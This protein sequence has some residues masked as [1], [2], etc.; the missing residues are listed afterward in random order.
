MRMIFHLPYKIDKNHQSGSNIRP[1]KMINA[2]KN[3]GY[4]VD[5]VMGYGKERKRQISLIKGKIKNGVQYD[6]LYSE[7]S[8][9][10]T[11]LTEK[12]H[13]PTYPFLDYNF[14][15]YCKKQGIKIGLFYRDIYWNFNDYKN[16]VSLLKRLYSLLFYKYDLFK[17]NKLLDVLYLPSTLM[18]EYIP[19]D[20]GIKIESLP[21]GVN[22]VVVEEGLKAKDNSYLEIFYV[23]GIG[24]LYNL[25]KI[26]QATKK[27]K[28]IKL[29]V[30]T[31]KK[32][33]D[34]EKNNYSSFLDDRI[35]II[36][37]RGEE[38]KPYFLKTDLA[39]LYIEPVKYR[40][41]AM[42]VKLFEY[43]GYGKPI[44]ASKGTA[45][46][47]FVEKHDI[48]WNIDYS[49][50]SLLD[51]LDYIY[52]NREII[53]EKRENIKK[54]LKDNRWEAR[55]EKVAKDLDGN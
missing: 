5:V 49:L 47:E 36:H 17:Y 12:H 30:C 32:E 3:I 21:P 27:R 23:G 11:L 16:R 40:S 1:L 9:M 2:F 43:I 44:I 26:F 51:T 8:T 39:N 35:N 20:F 48:G 53:K 42:P 28:Y 10:P 15:R 54:I 31:R 29:T 55:A 50:D 4:D 18:S 46:G 41:F 33:W 45:A 52:N 19:F 22:K 7:S 13:L 14:F 38:L 24:K 6:F 34:K 25:K 37:K